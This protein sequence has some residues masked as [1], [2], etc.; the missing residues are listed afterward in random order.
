MRLWILDPDKYTPVHYLRAVPAKRVHGYTAVQLACLGVLWLVKTSPLGIL[1]PFFLALLI[2]V[3]MF[4][5]RFFRSEHLALLDAEEV[6][7][8]EEFREVGV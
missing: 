1:F 4:L 8:D 2:P 5:R 3:R 7:A 6:P